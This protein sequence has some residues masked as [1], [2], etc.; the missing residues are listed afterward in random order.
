MTDR[1]KVRTVEE[2]F[3]Q[4]KTTG[5]AWFPVCDRTGG[6]L[7]LERCPLLHR[8][9]HLSS[10]VERDYW[11]LIVFNPHVAWYCEHPLQVSYPVDGKDIGTIFD[12]LIQYK[13]G[14]WSLKEIKYANLIDPKKITKRTQNQLAAQKGWT[15]DRGADY[16][17]VLD[18][19][20]R[21]NPLLLANL[22]QILPYLRTHRGMLSR[23]LTKPLFAILKDGVAVPLRVLEETLSPENPQAA[24]RLIFY[25]L[26]TGELSAPLE[27][28]PL[29]GR[30]LISRGKN[31]L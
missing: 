5:P 12:F 19:I 29:S 20:I 4:V 26:F 14:S 7:W 23:D 28:V 31:D 11:V 15:R 21:K 24:R 10:D 8:K 16:E 17:L 3:E 27:S 13:D 18:T 30:I 25:H 1:I 2:I 6:N 9:V 22:K